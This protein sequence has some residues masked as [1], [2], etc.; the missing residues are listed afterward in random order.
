MTNWKSSYTKTD[1]AASNPEVFAAAGVAYDSMILRPT[2][3]NYNSVS[4]I[5]QV[6][7]QNALLGQKTPQQAM[8]DAVEAANATIG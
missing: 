1:L 2:V 4:Q 5:L 6:E 7:I 3:A 8:D